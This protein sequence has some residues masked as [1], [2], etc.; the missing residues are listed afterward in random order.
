MITVDSAGWVE[1]FANGPLADD[2]EKYLDN[3]E[4]IVTP[5]IILYEVYKKVKREQGEENA[6]IAAAQLMK[7]QI[8]PFDATLALLAADCSITCALPMAD[9]IV[10]ATALQ[11]KCTVVT[12]DEH[13]RNLDNVIF[14]HR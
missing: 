1:Y 4:Q 6:L 3:P 12:S 8:V 2:Y 9:A 11:M 14:I 13:F 7:T 5:V 10:Y